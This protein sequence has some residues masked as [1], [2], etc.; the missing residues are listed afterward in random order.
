MISLTPS[1]TL[2][3]TAACAEVVFAVPHESEAS[4]S[5]VSLG[6]TEVKLGIVPAVI[7]P[8]V[9]AKIGRSAAR[10]LFL[11]GRR[12]TAQ[13]ALDIGLFGGGLDEGFEGLGHAG[14]FLAVL[15]DDGAVSKLL[16]VRGHH[17]LIHVVILGHENA[18]AAR[19]R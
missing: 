5:G 9:V 6:F 16:Q 14:V 11:T 1:D 19:R 12:F 15:G 3:P 10:E 4:C 13:H 17:H 7:S 18:Q 2:P 8:F